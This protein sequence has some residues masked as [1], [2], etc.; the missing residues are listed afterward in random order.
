MSVSLLRHIFHLTAR[1]GEE[2]RGSCG[3]QLPAVRVRFSSSQ[4]SLHLVESGCPCSVCLPYSVNSPLSVSLRTVLLRCGG[5]AKPPGVRQDDGVR[6]AVGRPH[7]SVKAS[8]RLGGRQSS[9]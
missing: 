2:P 4:L 1:A 7:G 6:R 3:S 9:G 5:A 8:P